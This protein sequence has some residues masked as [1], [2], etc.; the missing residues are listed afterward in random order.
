MCDTLAEAPMAIRAD[1]IPVLYEMEFP[2]MMACYGYLLE[3]GTH[4]CLLTGIR[5]WMNEKCHFCDVCGR[6]ENPP[7]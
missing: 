2:N 4:R 7:S 1:V 6:L 3:C 5:Q